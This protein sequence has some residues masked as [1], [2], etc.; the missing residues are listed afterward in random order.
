MA[1]L[2]SGHY[3]TLF[4]SAATG[5]EEDLYSTPELYWSSISI[6]LIVWSLTENLLLFLRTAEPTGQKG[7]W[8][9]HDFKYFMEAFNN[10]GH[11][12][13]TT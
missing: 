9:F 5:N 1:A 6:M 12:N 2:P 7:A 3:V 4:T 11:A 13:K 10:M 8:L